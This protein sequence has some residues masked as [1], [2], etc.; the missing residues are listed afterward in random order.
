MFMA[1]VKGYITGYLGY[2]SENESY[3]LLISDIWEN[4][5][6]HCGEQLEVEVNGKWVSTRIEMSLG[7][8]WYLVDTPYKGDLDFISARIVG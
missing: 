2:N 1:R 6:F 8:E 3:G 5:G 4:D 7:G